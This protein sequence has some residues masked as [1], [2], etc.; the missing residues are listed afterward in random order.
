MLR[1]SIF[2]NFTRNWSER[3]RF[4]RV[5][6]PQQSN[7][8]RYLQK[9]SFDH[10]VRKADWYANRYTDTLHRYNKEVQHRRAG[11]PTANRGLG[12]PWDSSEL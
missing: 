5:S 11:S 2:K 6:V 9:N 1:N 10:R 7:D 8:A 4:D 3:L 12:A